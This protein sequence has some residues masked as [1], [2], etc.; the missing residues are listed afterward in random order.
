MLE[1]DNENIPE[2]IAA[3]TAWE[4][5]KKLNKSIIVELFQVKLIFVGALLGPPI[6]S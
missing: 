5:Y 3:V 4:S 1:Q 2:E 6:I